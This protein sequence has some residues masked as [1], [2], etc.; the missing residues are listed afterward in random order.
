MTQRRRVTSV[1]EDMNLQQHLCKNL[2]S[3]FVSDVF[4]SYNRFMPI[5]Q[6]TGVSKAVQLC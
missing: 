3:D 2:T 6:N 5:A 1:P 4:L